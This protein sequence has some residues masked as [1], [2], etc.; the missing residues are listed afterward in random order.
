MLIAI[1]QAAEAAPQAQGIAALGIDIWSIVFQLINFAILFWVLQRFAFKPLLK[2]LRDRQEKITES[3]QAASRA[4][5][6]KE[7]AEKRQKELLAKARKDAE[8]IVQ[9]AKEHSSAIIV[10]AQAKAEMD[11]QKIK[12]AAQEAIQRDV[13]AAQAGLK[14]E[15]TKLVIQ[16]TSQVIGETLDSKKDEAL[17]K[18]A[19]DQALQS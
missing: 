19:L 12:A 5:Q 6:E 14:K 16:A 8:V 10:D 3:L 7:E 1:A 4:S 18:K 15:A 11:A 9:Q 17:I 2:V 13:V